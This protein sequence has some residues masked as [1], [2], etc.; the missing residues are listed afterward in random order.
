[1]VYNNK[2]GRRNDVGCFLDFQI[3]SLHMPKPNNGRRNHIGLAFCDG[4]PLPCV[5]RKQVD[6]L[7]CVGFTVN[8]ALHRENVNIII[9][10]VFIHVL[11]SPFP[12]TAPRNRRH[13]H[14]GLFFYLFFQVSS[15]GSWDGKMPRSSMVWR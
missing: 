12:F 1:M 3:S 5:H 7:L 8:H 15:L 13:H 6:I 10:G 4:H 14:F 9:S 11:A 2:N